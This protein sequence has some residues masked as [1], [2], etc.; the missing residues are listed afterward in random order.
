MRRHSLVLVLV[1]VAA[2]IV[3]LRRRTPSEYVD[4]HF[5]DGS[6][7]RLTTGPETAELIDDVQAVLDAVA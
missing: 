3:F 6:T 1:A 5:D 2:V 4:V 7:I